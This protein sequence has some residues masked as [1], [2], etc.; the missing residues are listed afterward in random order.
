[1]IK[2]VKRI[3]WALLCLISII[4]IFGCA[5][6]VVSLASSL[7]QRHGSFE[8]KIPELGKRPDILLIAEE[9][10]K[11]MGYKLVGKGPNNIHLENK[12]HMATTMMVGTHRHYTIMVMRMHGMISPGPGMIVP[13]QGMITPGA[14]EI[15]RMS[16]ELTI[17]VMA[18]GDF[19]R[20]GIGNAE[21]IANEFKEKLMAKAMQR[22]PIK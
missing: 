9:V 11:S 8:V 6:P 15:T 4:S 3:G 17:H 2:D 1:M 22:S 13:G 21:K 20:G 10:G 14:D 19:G 7:S 16:E 5:P 18:M 12:T